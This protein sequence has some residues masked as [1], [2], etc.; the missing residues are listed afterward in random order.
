MI[1]NGNIECAET[2]LDRRLLMKKRK[3]NSKNAMHR[4]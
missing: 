2:H 4:S 3:T 1:S